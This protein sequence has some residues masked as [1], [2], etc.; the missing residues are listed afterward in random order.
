M[1]K[2]GEPLGPSGFHSQQGRYSHLIDR[3][4]S[5]KHMVGVEGAL[6]QRV[7]SGEHLKQ[8]VNS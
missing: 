7:L 5:T 4:Q 3:D 6:C 8:V 1:V 2:D